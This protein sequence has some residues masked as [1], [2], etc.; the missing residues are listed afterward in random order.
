MEATYALTRIVDGLNFNFSHSEEDRWKI[1]KY[2]DKAKEIVGFLSKGKN[3]GLVADTGTGKTDIVFLSV[4]PFVLEKNMRVLFMTP[5]RI[6]TNQQFHAL[7]HITKNAYKISAKLIT[8]KI[9]KEERDWTTGEQFVFATPHVVLNDISCLSQFD[10]CIF[11]E[12]HHATGEYP[13]VHVAEEAWKQGKRIIALSATL[14]ESK[15]LLE[16]RKRLLHL[17]V[18]VDFV[19]RMPPRYEHTVFVEMDSALKEIDIEFKI[20]LRAIEK[21][22]GHAGI[23]IER[24]FQHMKRWTPLS[25][26]E[27]ERTHHEISTWPQK[28]GKFFRAMSLHAQYRKLLHAYRICITEGYGTFLSYVRDLE[29]QEKNKAA[30]HILSNAQFQSICS[31]AHR[32]KHPKAEMFKK[33]IETF[34]E[35]GTA[36][37]F[38]AQKKTGQIML[39]HFK[40]AGLRADFIFGGKEKSEDHQREALAL[41]AQ[42]KIYFLIS[43]SVIYEGIHVSEVNQILNYSIQTTATEHMQ[44]KGRSARVQVGHVMNFVMDHPFFDTRLYYAIVRK[45]QKLRELIHPEFVRASS[46]QLS[47]DLQPHLPY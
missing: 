27:L 29:S 8:G 45:E 6:L 36:I 13:Y 17:D 39:E 23:C 33:Y 47:L 43:T 44:G 46:P 37:I 31:L 16:E 12:G 7:M 2:R 11:D 40:R 38:V 9:S 30:Q 25:L 24:N 15:E 18:L 41:L 20:L 21:E 5:E 19:I 28:S 35:G 42:R 4:M 26:E 34:P 14:G 32:S 10:I 3:V 1:G 22:F